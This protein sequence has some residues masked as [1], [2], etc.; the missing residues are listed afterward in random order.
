MKNLKFV[1]FIKVKLSSLK[2]DKNLQTGSNTQKYKSNPR[3]VNIIYSIVGEISK[4]K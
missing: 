4:F 1:T 2:G 3:K